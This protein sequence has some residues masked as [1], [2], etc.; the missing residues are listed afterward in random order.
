VTG[1]STHFYTTQKGSLIQYN[2]LLKIP[3]KVDLKIPKEA[4]LAIHNE[5]IFYYFDNKII[6]ILP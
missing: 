5:N 4:K 2:K 1:N 3:T 6:S